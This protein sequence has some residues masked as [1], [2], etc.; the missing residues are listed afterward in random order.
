[1][2]FV[3]N[4]LPAKSV[5]AQGKFTIDHRAAANN[6]RFGISSAKKFLHKVSPEA[7]MRPA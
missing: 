1:L 2:I 4:L 3:N 7:Q 5:G 6:L